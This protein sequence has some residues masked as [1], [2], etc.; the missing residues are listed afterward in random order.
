MQFATPSDNCVVTS[1]LLFSAVSAVII[2][3][4]KYYG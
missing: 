4:A 1:M 3:G 2:C